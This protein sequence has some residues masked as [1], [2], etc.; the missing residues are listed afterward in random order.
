MPKLI[1]LILLI[2]LKRIK[3]IKYKKRGE[4]YLFIQKVLELTIYYQHSKILN[5]NIQFI[6][7]KNIF[8]KNL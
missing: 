7:R 6:F 4:N 3:K 1:G 5:Q 8:Y 2:T